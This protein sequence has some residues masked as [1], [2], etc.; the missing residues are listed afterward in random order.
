MTLDHASLIA[1]IQLGRALGRT[2]RQVA[3][4]LNV[5]KVPT[6]RGGPWTISKVSNTLRQFEIEQRLS[7]G[8]DEAEVDALILA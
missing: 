6:A 5:D 8:I 7:R 1:R 3:D 4:S 2:Y